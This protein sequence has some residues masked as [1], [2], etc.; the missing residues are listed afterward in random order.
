MNAVGIDVS[1]ENVAA[2]YHEMKRI[3][4]M[5]PEYETIIS[6]YGVGH[7]AAPR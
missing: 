7:K 1:K 3:A 6:M 2:M 4:E 5:L